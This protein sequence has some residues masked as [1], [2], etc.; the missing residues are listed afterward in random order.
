VKFVVFDGHNNFIENIVFSKY[1]SNC[2]TSV[3]NIYSIECFNT[4]SVDNFTINSVI[5]DINLNVPKPVE[6]IKSIYLNVD[7][8]SVDC[9]MLKPVEFIK[10]LYLNVIDM[11]KP[12]ELI[13]SVYLNVLDMSKPV[14]L[15]E[16]V[17][18][19]VDNHS[20]NF[21]LLSIMKCIESSMIMK[22]VLVEPMKI[23]LNIIN[24]FINKCIFIESADSIIIDLI[25]CIRARGCKQKLYNYQKITFAATSTVLPI[26]VLCIITEPVYIL[27]YDGI[28]KSTVNLMIRYPDTKEVSKLTLAEVEKYNSLLT[29]LYLYYSIIGITYHDISIAVNLLIM[30]VRKPD[31]TRF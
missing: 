17:Y 6:F 7:N 30:C 18:L 31:I 27:R 8:H 21:K 28:H 16:S 13:E 1:I 5:N 11:S 3:D 14:E 29:V 9:K 15:I 22:Y 2:D 19:N 23:V 12:V 4:F 25:L 10:S 26:N 24:T 20:I